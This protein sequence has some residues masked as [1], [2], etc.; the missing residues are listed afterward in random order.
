MSQNKNIAFTENLIN[1][2][3]ELFK[4][5]VDEAVDFL[6]EE[7][8]DIDKLDEDYSTFITKSLGKAEIEL[9]IQDR[10]KLIDLFTNAVVKMKQMGAEALS[11]ILTPL[12]IKQLSYTYRNLEKTI[13]EAEKNVIL[14]DER[15]L[16]IMEK[17]NQD[18]K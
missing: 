1:A 16:R 14:D 13:D 11:K 12:E 4:L 5:E 9:G 17:L 10:D 8:V 3:Y 18:E 15:I 2:L 6:K 7:G